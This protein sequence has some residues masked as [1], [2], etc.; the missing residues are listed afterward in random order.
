MTMHIDRPVPGEFRAAWKPTAPEDPI[1]KCRACGSA[2]VWYRPW[3]SACGGH[4]DVLYECRSCDREWWVE[5][6]DA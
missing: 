5:G 2:D 3:T 6:P 4:E 1:F